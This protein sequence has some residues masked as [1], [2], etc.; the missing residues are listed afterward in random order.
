[1]ELIKWTKQVDEINLVG[2]LKGTIEIRLQDGMSGISFLA[3]AR[4]LPLVK[5]CS[6]QLWAH[7]VSYSMGTG[8]LYCG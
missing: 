7:P 5:K 8:V 3:W 2:D 6:D 1:L 4:A